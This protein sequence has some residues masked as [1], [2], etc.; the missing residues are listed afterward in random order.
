MSQH[1][2]EQY[3][4][5]MELEP[6]VLFE[7]A[8]YET[9]F[10]DHLFEKW[11]QP[12][13]QFSRGEK[14]N[15]V[16]LARGTT[17]QEPYQILQIPENLK[18]PSRITPGI[19]SFH[20]CEE[21]PGDWLEDKKS[22]AIRSQVKKGGKSFGEKLNRA[23]IDVLLAAVPT[24]TRLPDMGLSEALANIYSEFVKAQ[25]DPNIFLFPKHLAAK[26][27]QKGIIVSDQKIKNVYYVGTTQA[28]LAAFGLRDIPDGIALM[29]DSSVGVTLWR[30]PEFRLVELRPFTPGVCGYMSLNPIV[31]NISGVMAI[32]GIE[33]A[34]DP[35]A[36]YGQQIIPYVDPNRMK[37]LR[38]ISSPDFDLAKLIRF[39]EEINACYTNK[40]YLATAMLIR[41][42]LDH[43][44]PIFSLKTFREVANNYGDGGKSFKNSML[45]LEKSARNIADAYL[46]LPIRPRES[47][48]HET[49]VDFHNDLDVLLGEIVRILK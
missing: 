20:H 14:G 3:F 46:H 6:D 4:A 10:G 42:V 36:T 17:E 28:G 34:M 31:K 41:A 25:F 49:Q 35:Q 43:V 23:F 11:E 37:E 15:G 39:C 13:Y 16:C 44:P 18:S 27:V 2:F 22:E 45:N 19:C 8:T 48:P 9:F 30:K 1:N 21:I 7:E 38:K 47:L 32:E 29:L 33:E 26:L 5:K 24:K 12:H 40:C